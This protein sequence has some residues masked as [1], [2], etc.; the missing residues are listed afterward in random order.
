M[1]ADMS[2]E[3]AAYLAKQ[4][5]ADLT[6]VFRKLGAF[7]PD[8]GDSSALALVAHLDGQI[9]AYQARDRVGMVGELLRTMVRGIVL[10]T[11]IEAAEARKGLSS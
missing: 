8:V 1:N 6:D 11:R 5:E 9:D 3:A 7:E 10:S 4:A 2:P